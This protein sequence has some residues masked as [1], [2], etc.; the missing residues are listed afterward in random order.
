[1]LFSILSLAA[2]QAGAGERALVPERLAGIETIDSDDVLEYLDGG[3]ARFIDARKPSDFRFATIP[4]SINCPITSGRY[5]IT[6]AEINAA[7]A[8]FESCADL[9]AVAMDTPVVVF[10]N[11]PECWRSSKGALALRKL[12]Y[13]MVYWYRIGMNDWKAQGLAME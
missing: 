5:E 8:D 10:C 7:V 2:V 13:R 9:E 3:G 6:D 1:M 4:T 11:G 12:G